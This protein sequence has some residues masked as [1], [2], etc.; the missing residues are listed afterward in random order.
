MG[1]GFYA[2][3]VLRAYASYMKWNN[4]N[5]YTTGAVRMEQVRV[6]V[7]IAQL[8]WRDLVMEQALLRMAYKWKPGGKP[9][10]YG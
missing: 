1:S 2:R 5:N 8:P 9:K 10:H 3:P 7:A 4:Y 6:P